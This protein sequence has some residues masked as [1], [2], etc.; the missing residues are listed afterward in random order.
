LAISQFES[1]VLWLYN[2]LALA[3]LDL[4]IRKAQETDQHDLS[5][6]DFLATNACWS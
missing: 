3:L 5:P 4:V 1:E 6:G 2:V